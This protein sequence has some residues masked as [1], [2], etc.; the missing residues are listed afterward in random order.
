MK[1]KILVM[2]LGLSLKTRKYLYQ[3]T[4]F[5]LILIFFFTNE[6]NNIGLDI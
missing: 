1:T 3:L 2:Y 4:Y 5:Y 6:Y